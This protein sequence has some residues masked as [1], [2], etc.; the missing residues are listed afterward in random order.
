[1]QAYKSPVH[2]VSATIGFTENLSVD[3]DAPQ[4]SHSKT[5]FSNSLTV[6]S[7]TQPGAEQ[8][9]VSAAASYSMQVFERSR[10]SVE[11]VLLAALEQ[12]EYQALHVQ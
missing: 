10:A 2:Y 9:P 12:F 3:C 5:P 1:M 11:S 8:P 6:S 4:R 7:C